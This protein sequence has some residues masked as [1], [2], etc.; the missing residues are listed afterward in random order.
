MKM[1]VYV[2]RMKREFSNQ[3]YGFIKSKTRINIHKHGILTGRAKTW[4]CTE[5]FNNKQNDATPFVRHNIFANVAVVSLHEGMI[6]NK[7]IIISLS[8]Q[9][10][11]NTDTER[12]RENKML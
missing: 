9:E 5:F 3:Q 11:K 10:K 4:K 2:L 8:A 7:K 12:E 1:C 6:I